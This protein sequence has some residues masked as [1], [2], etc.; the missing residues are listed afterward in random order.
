MTETRESYGKPA[1]SPIV[2]LDTYIYFVCYQVAQGNLDATDAARE[3]TTH[4]ARV[5]GR[6]LMGFVDSENA[7][8]PAGER[9]IDKGKKNEN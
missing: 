3:L 5:V 8:V 4:Q 7:P 9:W 2:P 6:A 1:T